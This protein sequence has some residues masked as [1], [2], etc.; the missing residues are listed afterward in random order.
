M[1][2]KKLLFF[3]YMWN[4]NL[5][6]TLFFS[7]ILIKILACDS[8]PFRDMPFEQATSEKSERTEGRVKGKRMDVNFFFLL[9]GTAVYRQTFLY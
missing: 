8:L 1:K 7:I 3:S 6:N 5:N 9:R 2:S 4:V